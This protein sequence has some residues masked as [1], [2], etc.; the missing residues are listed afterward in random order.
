M[1]D[2]RSD[3][4]NLAN[5]SA[6]PD[7]DAGTGTHPAL[8]VAPF[9]SRNLEAATM[10]AITRMHAAPAVPLELVETATTIAGIGAIASDL[11]SRRN[12]TP[13]LVQ[14]SHQNTRH[15]ANDS[16]L[17][18]RGHP[19]RWGDDDFHTTGHPAAI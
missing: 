3:S 14:Y 1:G 13:T 5:A 6:L 10:I 17:T 4:L 15:A 12:G 18:A 7:V 11:L 2:R 9:P 19:D 16:S 8:T